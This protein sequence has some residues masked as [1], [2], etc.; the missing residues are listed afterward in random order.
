MTEAFLGSIDYVLSNEGGFVNNPND[1]GKAT[2]WGITIYTLATHREKGVTIDD[3][4]NLTREEACEIYY[5]YYW[6]KANCQDL[7]EEIIATAIF[8]T[9]VLYGIHKATQM[10]QAAINEF[11]GST[12]YDEDGVMGDLTVNALNHMEASEFI[13]CFYQAITARITEIVEANPKNK[14]FEQGWL[15]RAHKLFSLIPRE[16]P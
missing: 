5:E 1:L 16:F 13:D 14:E 3:V 12:V 8:D 10:A 7:K 4:R 15:N 6:T 11:L 9:C 2:N